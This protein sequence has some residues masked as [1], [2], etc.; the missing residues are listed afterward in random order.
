MD[1]V[2]TGLDA[3]TALVLARQ[4]R[5]LQVLSIGKERHNVDIEGRSTE[6]QLRVQAALSKQ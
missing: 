2:G 1:A 3:W 6:F 4:L 5:R